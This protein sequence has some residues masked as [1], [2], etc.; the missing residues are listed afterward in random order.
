MFFSITNQA[1]E[2]FP[3]QY[4]LGK[5]VIN[6]DNGWRTHNH[7]EWQTVYKGYADSGHL[8]L[9]LQDILNQDVPTH[10]GNFCVIA[11][12]TNT[13]QLCIKTDVYRSFPIFYAQSKEVNNLI[14]LEHTVYTDNVIAVDEHLMVEYPLK[15]NFDVIGSV[16]TTQLSVDQVVNAIDS[17]L[18]QKTKNFIKFNRD[19]IKVHL[20]G[21]VDSLLVYSYLQ[22]HTDNYE[23]ITAQHFDYDPFY[24]MN[25]AS[26]RSFWGYNQIHHW[27]EACVLT[28]GAPGD[29]FMMRSPTTTDLFLKYHDT[30]IIELLKHPDWQQCLHWQYFNQPKHTKI[31]EQSMPELNDKSSMIKYLCNI[32][33]N[34]WQH[35][36]IGNT[37]TWTPLRDLEIFK[38]LLRLSPEDLLPQ[39]MN[40]AIS[41]RLINQNNSELGRLISDQK[42]SG[43][44]M[45]NLCDFYFKNCPTNPQ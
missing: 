21:G 19:P 4:Q 25:S 12:N 40:S 37:L 34:D 29:E 8:V 18:T 22:K 13:N 30:N 24:L 17:I 7:G 39:I 31:F 5:F 42:N 20:S 28:S 32:I 26:I 41:I 9:L 45:K 35:W 2:N 16:D 36:H 15:N 14:P 10:Q 43:N 27:R 23:I 33:I 44:Y 1:K 38:L 11:Y 6:T 3:N